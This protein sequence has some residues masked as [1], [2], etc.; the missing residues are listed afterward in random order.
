MGLLDKAQKRVQGAGEKL[1]IMTPPEIFMS[2]LREASGAGETRKAAYNLY[3]RFIGFK[4]V[5]DGAG[6]SAITA[7]T[8][9]ALAKAGLNVCV[10]DTSMLNPCQ[11]VLLKAPFADDEKYAGDWFNI[12]GTKKSVLTVSGYDKRISVL[13]FHKRGL[14]E[15]LSGEDRSD[16]VETALTE[17]S[18]KFD[19]ILLDIC[20]EATNVSVSALQ[21]SQA[22]IQVW[23]GGLH[24]TQNIDN[25]ITS[26]RLCACGMDKM[27]NV[28]LSK[29][30]ENNGMNWDTVLN[31]YGFRELGRVPLSYD[32]GGR[33]D[34]GGNL[35]DA[36][37]KSEGLQLFVGCISNIAAHILNLGTETITVKS[38]E[39][40]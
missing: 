25:F 33:L 31:H 3:Y 28:V 13:S 7:N 34:S 10:F 19:I 15:M 16:L 30:V 36:A 38:K 35:F 11:T 18:S 8:A 4:G 21:Q 40:A 6:C 29:I 37:G 39:D 32:L 12:S 20:S 17:L 23:T 24:I 9:I 14:M 2:L 27:R 5:K 22:V 1:K 26:N